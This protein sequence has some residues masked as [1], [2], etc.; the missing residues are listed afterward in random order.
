MP[1]REYTN[2][3]AWLWDVVRANKQEAH[4]WWYINISERW[5][6]ETFGGEGVVRR[7]SSSCSSNFKWWYDGDGGSGSGACVYLSVQISYYFSWSSSKLCASLSRF[8]SHSLFS[9]LSLVLAFFLYSMLAFF[10][11][12][13]SN[14]CECF[15]NAIRH[16]PKTKLS[17]DKEN[18]SEMNV[19][20]EKKYNSKQP[21]TISAA[22]TVVVVEAT[23]A[24]T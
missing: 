23:S 2:N 15:A 12:S 13:L 11:S 4:I 7:A 14:V 5:C 22:A 10:L 1:W 20:V 6:T 16:G 9:Q 21:I 18:R 8:P 17:T 24:V 3:I 19:Y